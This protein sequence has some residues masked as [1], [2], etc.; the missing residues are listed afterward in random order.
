MN[1]EDKESWKR[2]VRQRGVDC[3]QFSKQ[4]VRELIALGE[5]NVGASNP[6]NEVMTVLGRHILIMTG[7]KRAN[8]SKPQNHAASSSS[9]F[10]SAS[11]RRHSFNIVRE[12][13]KKMENEKQAQR[14]KQT[15]VIDLDAD[16]ADEA[17]SSQQSALKNAAADSPG[18]TTANN[19]VAGTVPT[20][21]LDQAKETTILQND[22]RHPSP[23]MNNTSSPLDNNDVEQPVMNKATKTATA[24]V[25]TSS[26]LDARPSQPLMPQNNHDDAKP[27]V[28]STTQNGIRNLPKRVTS[29]SVS[30][31]DSTMQPLSKSPFSNQNRE[32]SAPARL[33]SGTNAPP[34]D[35][36]VQNVQS[37]SGPH[38]SNVVSQ[39][40]DTVG[41]EKA[42][43]NNSKLATSMDGHPSHQN[44][45]STEEEQQFQNNRTR[46][47]SNQCIDLASNSVDVLR[48]QSSSVAMVARHDDSNVMDYSTE[49]KTAAPSS[50]ISMTWASSSTSTQVASSYRQPSEQDIMQ[51]S[52]PHLFRRWNME[53]YW[54]CTVC[55]DFNVDNVQEHCRKPRHIQNL[56]GKVESTGRTHTAAAH[57]GAL[58]GAGA[59]SSRET[60]TATSL[61]LSQR[62]VALSVAMPNS[63]NSTSN[64]LTGKAP[65][66]VAGACR[67]SKSTKGGTTDQRI[68]KDLRDATL[69]LQHQNSSNGT[70]IDRTVAL[71]VAVSKSS[72]ST[73]NDLTGKATGVAKPRHEN[74]SSSGDTADQSISKD[75]RDTTLS[76]QHQNA[77]NGA[78][79]DLNPMGTLHSEKSQIAKASED[80]KLQHNSS[81]GDNLKIN[82]TTS[83]AKADTNNYKETI[84]SNKHEATAPTNPGN[85]SDDRVYNKSNT[86]QI[87]H[88]R[89]SD[90]L[91]GKEQQ[92]QSSSSTVFYP[93]LETS[94]DKSE[95]FV[96]FDSNNNAQSEPGE[97]SKRVCQDQLAIE[98]LVAEQSKHWHISERTRVRQKSLKCF[99]P[100]TRK[101]GTLINGMFRCSLCNCENILSDHLLS[102]CR[103]LKH[104]TLLRAHLEKQEVGA[105]NEDANNAAHKTITRTL[106]LT[107]ASVK[108]KV[109]FKAM[110]DKV[111]TLACSLL[112]RAL[113]QVSVNPVQVGKDLEE[114]VMNRLKR[115][116]PFW[117]TV[118]LIT[119]GVTSKVQEVLPPT[120]LINTGAVFDVI[121]TPGHRFTLPMQRWGQKH[122]S[123]AW[124]KGETSLLLRMLPLNTP[125]SKRA[126]C[127]LWP[128]GTFLQI[129]GNGFKI[130]QRKQQSHDPTLWKG[131]CREFDAL[132][133]ISD[134]H[135]TALFEIAC[136]DNEPFVYV[137]SIDEYHSADQLF[138][139][140][141]RP[142]SSEAIDRLTHEEGILK[143]RGFA[144]Q[145]MT[146]TVD[147]PDD[148]DSSDIGRFVFSLKCPLSKR[149][150]ETP[151]RGKTCKHWQVSLIPCLSSPRL[152]ARHLL[153]FPSCSVTICIAT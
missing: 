35:G 142:T 135:R 127:H 94:K 45:Q 33:S 24:S 56:L 80:D 31:T 85:Q 58:N 76:L 123:H 137:L 21:S 141:M 60:A 95:I 52:K 91:Q 105:T 34:K 78:T 75:L 55:A 140:L 66:S 13:L 86:A 139:S 90:H 104:T 65:G 88:C 23:A 136:A 89:E 131:M 146:V 119:V 62:T 54:T 93:T 83:S 132:Q 107:T 10:P 26:S 8:H 99:V 101:N 121:F 17:S 115:W 149:I 114:K 57:G 152:Y 32:I 42:T 22:L 30:G 69:S 38:D 36:R 25:S 144:S 79:I 49:K 111:P 117:K 116:D 145:Q 148:H 46:D 82:S 11:V 70:T 110:E 63:S 47:T 112:G 3:A 72:N 113:T 4:F 122:G 118:S 53:G 14:T 59:V 48:N 15:I 100:Q 97:I 51:L 1:P 98:E 134:P 29:V 129:N 61:D 87:L 96:R 130:Q 108:K 68:S 138:D 9:Q 37:T 27:S 67:E 6:L 5:G 81:K 73:S 71:S 92:M 20:G 84:S 28:L 124:T 77:S 133:A 128:E 126:D 153:I 143:A 106:N 125:S 44:Q 19:H 12:L 16:E 151:V 18:A 2:I 39:C 150:I 120:N 147:K 7:Q 74:K 109:I 64:D 41:T 102:H 103:K 40:K 50:N 43:K